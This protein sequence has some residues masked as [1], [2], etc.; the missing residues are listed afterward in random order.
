MAGEPVA[1]VAADLSDGPSGLRGGDLG[2]FQRS[3]CFRSSKTAG[4]F[5]QE[6]S[7]VIETPIGTHVIQRLD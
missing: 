3:S 2:W 5:S 6:N 7:G 4:R 1:T